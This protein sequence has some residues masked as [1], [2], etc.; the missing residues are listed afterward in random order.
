M[1]VCTR[2]R[3]ILRYC[4]LLH[5]CLVCCMASD[6]G[7]DNLSSTGWSPAL[8]GGGVDLCLQWPLQNSTTIVARDSCASAEVFMQLTIIYTHTE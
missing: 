2:A 1:Y 6:N 8:M 5:S 4:W 7:C 3:L